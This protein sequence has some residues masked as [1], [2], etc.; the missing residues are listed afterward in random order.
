[1][2]VGHPRASHGEGP[3]LVEECYRDFADLLEG[4]AMSE[5]DALACGAIDA[6]DECD[7]HREDKRAGGGDHEHCEGAQRIA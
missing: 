2:H 7:R 1:M 3:G 4:G 5:D 6:A